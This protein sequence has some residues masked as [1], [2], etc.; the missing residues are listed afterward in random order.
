MLIKIQLLELSTMTHNKQIER[1][2]I[3]QR[4]QPPHKGHISMLEAA[5]NQ[6]TEVVI[7]IGSANVTD[8]KN[9]Y[10]AVERELM[11]RKSLEDLGVTNYS[12]VHIPDFEKDA[13]WMQYVQKHAKLD[14]Q[15]TILSGNSWVENIFGREGY[16]TVQPDKIIRGELVD[17][18]ATRLREMIINDDEIW[19][20][21]AASG[22]LHYFERLGGKERIAKFYKEGANQ[23]L[24]R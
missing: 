3:P 2:F 15:T 17:I 18:S 21:Y 9:P 12:F 19:K 10:T 13:E 5:C 8:Y 22:T 7:G 6:A 24:R 16:Q 14:Y 23:A 11:L 4:T 20:E 1:L